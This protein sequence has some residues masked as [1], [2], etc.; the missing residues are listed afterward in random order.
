LASRST[1][2]AFHVGPP[3][4]EG[5]QCWLFR[6]AG[7]PGRYRGWGVQEERERVALLAGQRGS[8]LDQF[9]DPG[10][11]ERARLVDGVP[12]VVV[13]LAAQVVSGRAGAGRPGTDARPAGD[14][15][16]GFPLRY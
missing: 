1:D 15:S 11:Q 9:P 8:R 16:S 3:G 5:L 12:V 14:S 13:V 2:W 7:R 10:I 4:L 6:R